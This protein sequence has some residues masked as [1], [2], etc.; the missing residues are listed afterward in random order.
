MPSTAVLV[1]VDVEVDVDVDVEICG[2]VESLISE[3]LISGFV[4]LELVLKSK[5]GFA[6]LELLGLLGSEL[7][8]AR[9]VVLGLGFGRPLARAGRAGAG[10]RTIPV[11]VESGLVLLVDIVD[12]VRRKKDARK[13]LGQRV[14]GREIGGFKDQSADEMMKKEEAARSRKREGPPRQEGTVWI[15]YRGKDEL[16]AI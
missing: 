14:V 16:G 15:P 9:E 10:G 13:R 2:V 4:G 6:E 3:S 11:G 12:V 1:E 8:L 7:E 5:L